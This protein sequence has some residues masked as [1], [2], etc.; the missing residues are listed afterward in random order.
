[1]T[2]DATRNM[3]T[4]LHLLTLAFGLA[5]I[6]HAQQFGYSGH[7]G[8]EANEWCSLGTNYS[9][10]CGGAEQSPINIVTGDAALEKNLPKLKFHHPGSTPLRITNNGHT[11]QANVP[12]GATLE[13]DGLTYNLLQFHF[14]TPSE[15]T[16]N[17]RHAPIEMQLVHKTTDGAHAAVVGVFIVPG[18]KNDEM[19]KIWSVLPA[20]E[21]GT[22]TAEKFR[23]K[24][25]LPSGNL[26]SFRYNGSLTTPPCTEGIK[27]NL[28]VHSISMSDEQIS[29]FKT[30]FSGREFPAGNAR[31]AQALHGRRIVTDEKR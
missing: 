21:G 25:L 20:K 5:A 23:L 15:H 31:P 22:A 9:A 19:E 24:Q 6:A 1:M 12:A 29:Q 7:N 17:G 30:L 26:T 3:K 2:L 14:H 28:L 10:C 16:M 13:I 18:K 4:P 11:V 8:P 27:W